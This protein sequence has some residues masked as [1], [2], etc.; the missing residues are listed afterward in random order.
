M[1]GE[2]LIAPVDEPP[3]DLLLTSHGQIDQPLV[4]ELQGIVE[5]LVRR[6]VIVH[7]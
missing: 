1:F 4:R 6:S 3:I 5:R 7:V 2:P